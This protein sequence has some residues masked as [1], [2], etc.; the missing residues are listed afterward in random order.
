MSQDVVKKTVILSQLE[1]DVQSLKCSMDLLQALV[2][3]QQE[4]IDSI[5]DFIQLTKHDVKGA[6]TA[7][8]TVLSTVDTRG[9]LYVSGLMGVL[10]VI[11]GVMLF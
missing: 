6:E 10:G 9:Y 3:E 8:S 4:S 5:E 2:Y 11:V 7:L 1:S